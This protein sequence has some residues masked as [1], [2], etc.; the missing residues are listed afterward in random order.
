MMPSAP[1]PDLLDDFAQPGEGAR[2][3]SVFT[4]RV[5]GGVSVA[6]GAV[7]VVTGRRAL[8]LRG[9]VSLERNGGFVQVARPL[10]DASGPLD[11]RHA[12]GLSLD[13]CGTPGPY[14]VHLRTAD[15]RA[16]WQHYRAPLPV[17]A[18][19]R[20]VEVPWSAFTPS[21][22]DRPLDVR[23]LTRLGIVGARE[24]FDADIALARLA[25]VPAGAR[26]P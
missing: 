10:G 13:V 11:A 5:M 3:W 15:T 1:H 8:R 21:G 19:W 24:A 20:T 6:Q 18:D 26:A 9:R 22:L 17:T 2:A 14:F 25:L 23:A 7:E 12:L 16:P 4:D